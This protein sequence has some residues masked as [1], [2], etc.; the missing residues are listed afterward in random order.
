MEKSNQLLIFIV[1]RT[2]N[3]KINQQSA[4]KQGLNFI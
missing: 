3:S 1:K 4:E 2:L